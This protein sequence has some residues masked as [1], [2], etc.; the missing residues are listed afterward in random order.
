MTVYKLGKLPARP[1][2]A[3]L[4]WSDYANHSPHSDWTAWLVRT[5]LTGA[6][7]LLSVTAPAG[8]P[9]VPSEFGLTHLPANWQMLEND[10]VGDCVEAGTIH[11]IMRWT[12]W[13]QGVQAQFLDSDA[14]NLYEAWTGYTPANPN[15]DGG[16]DMV[17]AAK[18]WVVS[19]VKDQSGTVHKILC[20][21]SLDPTNEDELAES[22]YVLGAIGVGVQFPSQ[23]MDDFNAGR[24]WDAI[25]NLTD[26]DLAG[27]HFIPVIGRKANGNFVCVTWGR[28]QEITPAGLK[29]NS[30]E[31]LAYLTDDWVLTATNQTPLLMNFDQLR[32]DI[33]QFVQEA[34]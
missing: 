27:G 33:R 22:V 17:D 32:Q 20:Y 13:A 8:L 30:D 25:P 24:P 5:S 28:T 9:P 15:S 14:L 16:T 19:G 12:L 31:A 1:G 34:A 11:C 29:Q 7:G 2:A 3:P 4:R 6:P 21:L 26:A 23:W 18:R 10:Q